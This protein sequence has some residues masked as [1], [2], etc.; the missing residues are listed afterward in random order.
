MRA[1]IRR[2]VDVLGSRPAGGRVGAAEDQFLKHGNS[3]THNV[4]FS[5][6]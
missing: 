2:N 5:A 4:P 1:E 6:E 3:V